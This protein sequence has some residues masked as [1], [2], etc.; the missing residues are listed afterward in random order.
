MPV[1]SWAQNW[2]IDLLRDINVHRNVALDPT[3][4]ALSTSTVPLSFAVPAGAIAYALIKKDENSRKNALLIT[5][6][7]GSAAAITL[8]TKYAVNRDRPYVKYPEIENNKEEGSPSFPSAHT[9]FS[10][11]MATSVSLAY[12]KWYIIAPSYLWAGAVGYSRMHLG[13]HYP[14]D[15]FIGAIIGAGSTYLSWRLNDWMDLNWKSTF[16]P[17][18][19]HKTIDYDDLLSDQPSLVIE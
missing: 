18:T 8:M 6:S 17:S 19:A 9:S 4:K 5:T 15:V 16:R 3:F 12:P 7:L 10:F 11:S 1:L 14:S 13:V 2:D